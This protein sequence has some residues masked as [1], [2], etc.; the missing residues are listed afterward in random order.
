[1]AILALQA[2]AMN[3]EL[4]MLELKDIRVNYGAA[5]ALWGVSLHVDAGELVC[6]VGPNGAGKSTLINAIAGVHK[7]HV[8][9]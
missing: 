2:L 7:A 6:V 9:V 1:M 3:L 5:P 8:V 4:V